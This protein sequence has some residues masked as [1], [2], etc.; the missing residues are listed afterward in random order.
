MQQAS[1]MKRGMLSLAALE[2]LVEEPVTA[3]CGEEG[4]TPY[5]TQGYQ[6]SFCDRA[7]GVDAAT[8][9]DEWWYDPFRW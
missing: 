4:D 7:E 9:H 2:P 1:G 8:F 6:A 3:G 5:P